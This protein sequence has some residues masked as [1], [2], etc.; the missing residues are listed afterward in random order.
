MNNESEQSLKDFL[1]A[2]N[3]R[4]PTHIRH[5]IFNHLNE[6]EEYVILSLQH[7][8]IKDPDRAEEWNKRTVLPVVMG[9]MR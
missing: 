6:D 7:Q 5:S 1:L 8:E 4:L 9:T 3:S 2:V